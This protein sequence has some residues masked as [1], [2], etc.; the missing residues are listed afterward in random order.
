MQAVTPPLSA[1]GLSAVVAFISALS[2]ASERVIAVLKTLFPW[3]GEPKTPTDRK[4][5]RGNEEEQRRVL[6]MLLSY[7]SSLSIC[8]L[9]I[10]GLRV[11]L[12]G[13]PDRSISVFVLAGLA[14]GGSAFWAQIIGV[15]SAIKDLK[16]K[17][18]R[19]LTA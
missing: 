15:L 1:E 11:P 9:F 14:V 3:L 13:A 2:I 12:P 18:F 17:E 19:K 7:L 4:L 5:L 8:V 16:Q 10:G 6:V